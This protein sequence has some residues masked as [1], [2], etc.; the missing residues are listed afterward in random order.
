MYE[1]DGQPFD[2][3]MKTLAHLALGL[4]GV[5]ETFFVANKKK[6]LYEMKKKKRIIIRVWYVQIKIF[7]IFC[8]GEIV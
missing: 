3:K 2:V 4:F 1:S 8:E 7:I 5:V 6:S